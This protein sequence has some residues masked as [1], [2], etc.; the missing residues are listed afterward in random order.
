VLIAKHEAATRGRH[1]SWARDGRHQH[2]LELAKPLQHPEMAR[3]R[4]TRKT[5]VWPTGRACL[6]RNYRRAYRRGTVGGQR[7]HRDFD[8]RLEVGLVHRLASRS[9]QVYPDNVL[10]PCFGEQGGARGDGR[11][12]GVGPFDGHGVR[13]VPDGR[14]T[15]LEGELCRAGFWRQVRALVRTI[16]QVNNGAG[17][18]ATGR[19]ECSRD[20]HAARSELVTANVECMDMASGFGTGDCALGAFAG[21]EAMCGIGTTGQHHH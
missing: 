4:W 13:A 1:L 9:A 19:A 12:G 11:C 15:D 14:A 16:T 10:R 8:H 20:V 5:K 7:L 18:D 3:T 2:R 21:C 17:A 6:Q